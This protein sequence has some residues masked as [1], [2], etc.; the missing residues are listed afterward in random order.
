METTNRENN[1]LEQGANAALN[2]K[3][4]GNEA[5]NIGE[6]AKQAFGDSKP[7]DTDRAN[8]KPF[9]A[10]N[11]QKSRTAS[12]SA[13]EKEKG[14]DGKEKK[15]DSDKQADTTGKDTSKNPEKSTDGKGIQT[16]SSGSDTAG[17]ASSQAAK[18]AA[19]AVG[20]SAA[21]ASTGGA[22]EAAALPADAVRKALKKEQELENYQDKKKDKHSLFMWILVPVMVFVML[23]MGIIAAVNPISI[24][25]SIGTKVQ[26]TAEGILDDIKDFFSDGD[27]KDIARFDMA[28]DYATT[29]PVYT[30]MIDDH[31]NNA[32]EWRKSQLKE[33][34][35]F[36]DENGQKYQMD[37]ELTLAEFEAQGN[38][39]TGVNY[40][41][42]LAGYAVS[43]YDVKESTLK[44]F[45]ES[46]KNGYGDMLKVTYTYTDEQGNPF[47]NRQVIP[48]PIYKYN[49]EIMRMGKTKYLNYLQRLQEGT[50]ELKQ[51]DI[52][53]LNADIKEKK[54]DI[55]KIDQAIK[56]ADTVQK[57]ELKKEKKTLKAEIKEKQ[58]LI[59]ALKDGEI[60]SSY[61]YITEDNFKGTKHDVTVYT[62][63]KNANGESVVDHYVTNEEGEQG[64][65]M[66]LFSEEAFGESY[67]IISGT[68]INKPEIEEKYYAKVTLNPFCDTDIFEIFDIE[69]EAIYPPS[70]GVD[71]AITNEEMY[72]H[73]YDVLKEE[74]DICNYTSN[75]SGH[76][77]SLT[78][79]EI[80]GYLNNIS[81]ASKNRQQLV[82]T[83]LTLT[84][85]IYYEWGGKPTNPGWNDRWWQPTT[86]GYTGLDCSGYIK[87]V[88]WTAWGEGYEGLDGTAGISSNC[89]I[90]SKSELQ[91]GDLG[92]IFIG[93]SSNTATNHVGMY[94]GKNQSGNDLW[95]H[96]TGGEQR[97]VVI[98]ENY[99]RFHYYLRVNSAALEGDNHWTD[100]ID[101]P[102]GG[103]EN[104]D[105][106]YVITTCMLQEYG[107]VDSGK[108]AVAEAMCNYLILKGYPVN[109][110]N[111]YLL[112]SNQ[113]HKNYL[114]SYKQLFEAHSIQPR[115][116]TQNDYEIVLR[117]LG[118]SRSQ[119]TNSNVAYWRG[120]NTAIPANGIFYRQ[121]PDSGGNKF[122]SYQ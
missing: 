42:V 68:G 61:Q 71:S 30:G 26:S 34:L 73:Y 79:E 118:G 25:K 94:M 69:P 92:V 60:P 14:K 24:I 15:S 113:I 76:V 104:Q 13:P 53:S 112:A 63:A 31:L 88:Y 120:K 86:N 2:A 58:S 90:I 37:Y 56:E 67:Y 84:G 62:I 52:E 11:E 49:S 40:G 38:P 101:F 119:I 20:R 23:F 41:A 83:A 27:E 80:Q 117:A 103:I 109:Q 93:G 100:T 81:Y 87:W 17:R 74:T 5:K 18:E 46:M 121:I 8:Q 98:S 55:K 51:A 64:N 70:E 6:K 16:K 47:V 9:N 105:E 95:I 4:L 102:Y 78:S 19:K 1:D 106:M 111:L 108:T 7:P 110:H 116:P 122:F 85:A 33:H 3:M 59:Q 91:P 99:D 45:Q 44:R 75:N 12:A 22:S 114:E 48:L 72:N 115:V 35:S 66:V 43:D 10:P 89:T 54:K 28:S 107:G 96:C 50:E 32:L 65:L 97:T 82:K 77:C 29:I 36:T 21:A 39:F 57:E